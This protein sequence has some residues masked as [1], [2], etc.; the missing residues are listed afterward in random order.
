MNK[1]FIGILAIAVVAVLGGIFIFGGNGAQ[2]QQQEASMTGEEDSNLPKHDSTEETLSEGNE[3]SDEPL[4]MPGEGELKEF[5][6][7]G[8]NFKFSL[9]KIE[10]N[11]GDVVRIVFT[12]QE[13]FHDW[14][15]DEFGVATNQ[16]QA[17]QQETIEF[18][19][20]QAGQFEYYCSV[21]N[22]RALG[23]VGTLVV[24]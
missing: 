4:L 9:L 3:S 8:T 19:A 17:G 12:S 1:L 7:D 2:D 24:N 10:V 21:G 14:K 11:K 22:H 18:V 13:G 16:I 5:E 15:I 20:D 6:V 23:M